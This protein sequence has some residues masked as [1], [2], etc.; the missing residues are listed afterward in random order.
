MDER[1]GSK[2]SDLFLQKWWGF[3]YKDTNSLICLHVCTRRWGQDWGQQPSPFPPQPIWSKK[4]ALYGWSRYY[5]GGHTCLKFQSKVL[6]PLSPPLKW[7]W[8]CLLMYASH[9]FI[10]LLDSAIL[11]W[12]WSGDWR[13]TISLLI[14]VMWTI[15]RELT[16]S[17]SFF[18]LQTF[19]DK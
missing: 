5:L 6:S 17:T 9:G 15:L 1:F 12:E 8:S 7:K 11:G 2:L 18:S 14:K 19:I 13:V 16:F 3:C 4:C 10:W